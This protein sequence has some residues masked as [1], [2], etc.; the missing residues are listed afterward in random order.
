MGWGGEGKEGEGEEGTDTVG[1]SEDH[2]PLKVTIVTFQK[3][4]VWLERYTPAEM[5]EGRSIPV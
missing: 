4:F 1:G 2:F 5:K 3:F